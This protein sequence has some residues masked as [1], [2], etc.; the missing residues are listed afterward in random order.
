M[1][2]NQPNQAAQRILERGWKMEELVRHANFCLFRPT[3]PNQA[4]WGV[5]P[6]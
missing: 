4:Q 2:Q 5:Y 1:N 3:F 6:I